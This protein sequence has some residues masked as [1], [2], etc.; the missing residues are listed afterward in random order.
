MIRDC[1]VKMRVT[2]TRL[3]VAPRDGVDDRG[4]QIE[5]GHTGGCCGDDSGNGKDE[6]LESI[7]S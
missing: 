6:D 3:A 2:G 7:E 1:E 4:G 5:Q